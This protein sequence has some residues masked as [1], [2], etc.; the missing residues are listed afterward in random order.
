MGNSYQIIRSTRKTI[1]IQIKPDG[2]ILV[3]CPSRMRV[4]EV[5]KFVES[6]E[7]WIQKHL[8][9]HPMQEIK[10]LTET[11]LAQLREQTR[12][13]VT[14]RAAFFAPILGVTYR[15]ITIRT[16]H[17]L[18]GSCSSQGNLN[19]NC[20]LALT[21]SEILDYVVVHE[22][23]HRKEMNHSDKFWREVAQI[24]PDYK[25]RKAWLKE[26]GNSLIARL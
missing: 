19:F 23:C 11:E 4:E 12:K 21:P 2:Q 25:V 26:N 24:L 8:P 20:L 14:A 16:Q 1:S 17:T 3:R 6:K 9:K 10:K 18:W 7:A 22:L 13:L 5:H 15:K